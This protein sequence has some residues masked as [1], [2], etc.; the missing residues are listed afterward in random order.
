MKSEEEHRVLVYGESD[1]GDQYRTICFT[2][3]LREA[4]QFL[5][6]YSFE[7]VLINMEGNGA[8][9]F[10]DIARSVPGYAMVPFIVLAKDYRYESWARLELHS[11]EY[12]I[13]P[14]ERQDICRVV[15]TLLSRMWDR[16]E[17]TY[18]TLRQGGSVFYLPLCEVMYIL[19]LNRQGLVATKD[20]VYE[21]PYL[22]LQDYLERYSPYL[23]QCH[24]AMAVSRRWVDAINFTES[25]LE[26]QGQRFPI[27]R[28]YRA[29][30]KRAFDGR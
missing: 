26:I 2:Q 30:V 17:E 25:Y 10:G 19:I 9:S 29:A 13:Q 15:Y 7:L 5:E 24:R 3:E 12:L 14:L 21:V 20:K 6:D 27:G 22:V 18:M 23:V 28:K 8:K 4:I 1:L 11:Y 16:R